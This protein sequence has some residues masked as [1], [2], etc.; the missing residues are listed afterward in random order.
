[1]AV[2]VP[3][4]NPLCR[5]VLRSAASIA[6]GYGPTCAERLGVAHA[7]LERVAAKAKKLRAR[8]AELPAV[9]PR[10]CELAFVA[11]IAAPNAGVD[12]S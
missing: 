6:L 9:D 8:V 1:M 7:R 5:R 4:K 12:C 10:Q 2:V 11:E 3:C